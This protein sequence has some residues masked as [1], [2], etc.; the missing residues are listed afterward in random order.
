MHQICHC[1]L[2]FESNQL[3]PF[4]DRDQLVSSPVL[5]VSTN[6]LVAGY[7]VSR[8]LHIV[9][10]A[11]PTDIRKYGRLQRRMGV[12]GV[13]GS[14]GPGSMVHNLTTST[15]Q[16]LGVTGATAVSTLQCCPDMQDTTLCFCTDSQTAVVCTSRQ[17]ST[18]LLMISETLF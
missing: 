9:D 6:T 13:T 4:K 15:Y 17:G 12:P 7:T 10:S 11:I 8:Y 1:R 16:C 5:L 14:S 3:F 2:S 18:K